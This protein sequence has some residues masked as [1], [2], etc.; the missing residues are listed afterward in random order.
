MIHGSGSATKEQ[1]MFVE[2]GLVMAA[3]HEWLERWTAGPTEPGG[4]P[5]PT[6][7]IAPAPRLLD[8]TGQPRELSEFWR[9]GPALVM[10]WRHFGCGCGFTRAERLDA[11]WEAYANA[12][13]NPVIIGQGEPLRAAAYREEHGLRCPILCDP[14]HDAYR[15]FGIGHW[16]FER[17]LPDAPVELAAHPRHL[18]I[19]FQDERRAL[20]QPLVDDPWRAVSEFVIGT[21]GR[22]RLTWAYQYCE[23]FPHPQVLL[24]AARLS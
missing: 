19:E 15:A 5:L 8:H 24:S 4:E 17:V 12:G 10:F 3:E 6:G 16:Q 20:H 7:S 9:D 23:D 2:Q 21:N 22:V 18:G 13:L 11:E 1:T 14:D